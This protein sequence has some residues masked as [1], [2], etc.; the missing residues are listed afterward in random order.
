[1][2]IPQSNKYMT[3][4]EPV[5]IKCSIGPYPR[6]MPEGM[7]DSMPKVSVKFSNGNEKTL[8]E[9]YP[10][11][12]SFTEAELIGLTEESARKLKIEKDKKY[13]QS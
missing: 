5:I 10:D 8:F 12:I 3:S 1:L 9:F 7:I 6:P 4:T 13:I 2:L 11:E